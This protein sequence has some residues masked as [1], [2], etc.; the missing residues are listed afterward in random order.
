MYQQLGRNALQ[1]AEEQSKPPSLRIKARYYDEILLIVG[2]HAMVEAMANRVKQYYCSLGYVWLFVGVLNLVVISTDGAAGSE[3]GFPPMHPLLASQKRRF[4]LI[5][6][7]C[8]D[9]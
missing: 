5:P 6:H 4:P 3:R 8:V 2:H 7:S 9:Y 1:A